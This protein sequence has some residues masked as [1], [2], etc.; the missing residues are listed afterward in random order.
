MEKRKQRE[1]KNTDKREAK[2]MS[3]LK[4]RKKTVTAKEIKI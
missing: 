2:E 1:G 3:K 4:E